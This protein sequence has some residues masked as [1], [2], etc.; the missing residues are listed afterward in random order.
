MSPR[1]PAQAKPDAAS[2]E[3]EVYTAQRT[4][5][6]VD[7][8]AL[9]GVLVQLVRQRTDVDLSHYKDS[10]FHRQLQRRMLELGCAG[11]DAYIKHLEAH[12]DELHRLQRSLL[13]SVTR[14]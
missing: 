4:A 13:I 14:F 8:A 11:L 3:V 6:S 1:L 5:S 12:P 9:L 10:T 2:A 7:E